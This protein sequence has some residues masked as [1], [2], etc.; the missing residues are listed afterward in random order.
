MWTECN[1]KYSTSSLAAEAFRDGGCRGATPEESPPSP[2]LAGAEAGFSP[3]L[4]VYF[5]GGHKLAAVRSSS[6]RPRSASVPFGC[7]DDAAS[8]RW[9]RL[10]G[11]PLKPQVTAIIFNSQIV[12]EGEWHRICL[13]L[14]G[15][16]GAQMG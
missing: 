12:L 11:R 14:F 13:R 3:A 10:H 8:Y 7:Q 1:N 4:P 16:T 6:Q 2:F 9:L 5:L 15:Q